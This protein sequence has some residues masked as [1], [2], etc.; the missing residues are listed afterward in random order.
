MQECAIVLGSCSLRESRGK[1]GS[2]VRLAGK[3]W[4]PG[5]GKVFVFLLVS[6]EC[7]R[8]RGDSHGVVMRHGWMDKIAL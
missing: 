4:K 6:G 7:S 5:G 1:S 8:G 3:S 2:T